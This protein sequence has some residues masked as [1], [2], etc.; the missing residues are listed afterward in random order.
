MKAIIP[1]FIILICLGYINFST[2][3]EAQ[4]DLAGQDT[5]DKKSRPNCSSVLQRVCRGL[6][7]SQ[8]IIKTYSDGTI[9]FIPRFKNSKSPSRQMQTLLN[10]NEI[11]QVNFSS[12]IQAI[13]LKLIDIAIGDIEKATSSSIRNTPYAHLK[14][15]D[16]VV[17]DRE[18]CRR[19]GRSPIVASIDGQNNRLTICPLMTHLNS[20]T[21]VAILAHEIGH[22]VDPCRYRVATNEINNHPYSNIHSCLAK[23]RTSR[24]QC[25]RSVATEEDEVYAD[26]AGATLARRFLEQNPNLVQFSSFPLERALEYFNFRLVGCED[27]LNFEF[28]P[29]FYGPRRIQNF[30]GCHDETIGRTDLPSHRLCRAE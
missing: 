3:K 1:I 7:E 28:L 2:T 18:R 26:L 23:G 13:F 22:A 30:I 19:S 4:R 12:N 29:A 27:P 6:N 8:G 9:L 16:L 11:N 10:S 21:L 15:M 24:A 17:V 20:A 25:R 5:I 14:S